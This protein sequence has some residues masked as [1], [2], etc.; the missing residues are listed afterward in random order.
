MKYNAKSTEK[1]DHFVNSFG[2]ST[3]KMR[4]QNMIMLLINSLKQN[5][6]Y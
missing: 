6:R 4:I 5:S 2:Y 1:L 3:G